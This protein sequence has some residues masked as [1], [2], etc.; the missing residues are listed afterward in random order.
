MFKGIKF[1]LNEKLYLRDPQNT[2]F[3]QR[4]LSNSILLMNEIG[5]EAFT[6]KKLAARMNSAEAS[7]YRY[8]ENK[9]LLLIYLTNWYWEW[10]QYLIEVNTKNVEDP[11]RRLRI[12]LH[13]IVNAAVESHLNEYIN[14]RILHRIIIN[15][16]SKSYHVR[17]VD[18]INRLGFFLSYK[19]LVEVI[20][21][22]ILEVNPDFSYSKSLASNLFEMS[23]N[24]IYFAEHLPRLTDIKNNEDLLDEL[25]E[26]LVFL[27]FRLL[28][29]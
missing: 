8:F 4:L 1:D 13:T 10:V 3:G 24:Q 11:A 5:F 2:E 27:T 29:R 20:A 21:E 7:V 6:F 18:E 19:K 16:G 12:I 26:M 15:E 25:E 9:H 23:N 28:D 17:D 22:T 14:E